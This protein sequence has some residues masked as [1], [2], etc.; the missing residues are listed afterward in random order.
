[1]TT[2][3]SNER[4]APLIGCLAYA[5]LPYRPLDKFVR[6]LLGDN[7]SGGGDPGWWIVWIESEA[8]A[9]DPVGWR[10]FTESGDDLSGCFEAWLD[11]EPGVSSHSCGYYSKEEVF[12]CVRE[13]LVR[14]EHYWP[15][16]AAEARALSSRFAWPQRA[17]KTHSACS[18]LLGLVRAMLRKAVPRV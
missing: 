11:D 5:L 17:V 7:G 12:A 6:S 13:Q 4:F 2:D 10:R 18:S 1:M 9:A 16:W 15:E 14:F 3:C 8:D